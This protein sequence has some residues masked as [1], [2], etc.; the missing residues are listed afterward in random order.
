MQI[1]RPCEICVQLKCIY[2]VNLLFFILFFFKVPPSVGLVFNFTHE[3]RT[4]RH[5]RKRPLT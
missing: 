1:T 2:N 5:K 3:P 4:P